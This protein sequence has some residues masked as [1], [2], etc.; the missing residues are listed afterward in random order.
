VFSESTQRLVRQRASGTC[1][2]LST[3]CAHYGRC[4][5]AGLEFH[6]KIPTAKSGD[7]KP[8]NCLLMCKECHQRAHIAS[9][10][11]GRL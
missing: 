11:F 1:E 5:Q 10:T 4:R 9:D 7:D 3:S 2:C 6:H 8:S